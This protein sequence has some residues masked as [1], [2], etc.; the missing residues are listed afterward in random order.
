[1]LKLVEGIQNSVLSSWTSHLHSISPNGQIML[2]PA[3]LSLEVQVTFIVP[4]G[5]YKERKSQAM[6]TTSDNMASR[7]PFKGILSTTKNV[8]VD[9]ICRLCPLDAVLSTQEWAGC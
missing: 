8:M 3:H 1:M 4:Q 6:C 7:C 2:Y 5:G 9:A